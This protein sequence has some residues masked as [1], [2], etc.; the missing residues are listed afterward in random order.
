MS[1]YC[2][3]CDI[4]YESK[5]EHVIRA[6]EH[7][8]AIQAAERDVIAAAEKCTSMEWPAYPQEYTTMIDADRLRDLLTAVAKLREV[9][10]NERQNHQPSIVGRI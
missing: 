3:I 2:A 4:Y 1:E 5:L 9:R 10:G 7:L 6:R 8:T